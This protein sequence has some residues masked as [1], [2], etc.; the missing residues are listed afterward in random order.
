MKWFWRGLLTL[1]GILVIAFIVFRTPDTD[2]AEM[3]AKYGGPPSQFVDIGG[4]VTVHLRDEGPKDAPAIMLLHGSNAD[5]LT[6]DPWVAALKDRYRVIRFDTVG[7]GLTGAAPG[8]DYSGQAM[9][10]LVGKVADKLVV[11]RVAVN[12]SLDDRAFAKPGVPVA[13]RKGVVID[14]RAVTAPS[15]PRPTP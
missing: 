15:A 7:H 9:A 5:L 1:I 10:D 6:W 14:A 8:K 13:R 12:P 2:P 11:D 3:R 4:G